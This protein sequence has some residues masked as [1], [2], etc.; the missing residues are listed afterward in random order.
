MGEGWCWRRERRHSLIN[1]RVIKTR[2][3]LGTEGK[4]NHTCFQGITADFMEVIGLVPGLKGLGSW[5][6]AGVRAPPQRVLAVP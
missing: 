1:A 6:G 2:S 3:A 5:P 4:E